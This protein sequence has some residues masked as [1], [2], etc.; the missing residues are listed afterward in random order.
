MC[1]T[2]AIQPQAP[3]VA[4][5]PRLDSQKAPIIEPVATC[6]CVV[7]PVR[8][9]SQFQSTARRQLCSRISPNVSNGR[10]L[11]CSNSRILECSNARI[12]TRGHTIS[13]MHLSRRRNRKPSNRNQCNAGAERRSTRF[14]RLPT[15]RDSTAPQWGPQSARL[16]HGQTQR[17]GDTEIQRCWESLKVASRRVTRTQTSPKHTHT[18]SREVR[19]LSKK[20]TCRAF[21]SVL[22]VPRGSLAL[23]RLRSLG[24]F[25]ANYLVHLEHGAGG[26]R[27]K[28]D[29]PEF[30]RVQI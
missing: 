20:H 12:T 13:P 27:R 6:G 9:G 5:I 3:T 28:L 4:N 14:H 7:G 26:A 21:A 1:P 25:G 30:G 16:R 10:T 29:A 11:E 15:P 23:G 19:F 8:E 22:V 24:R 2:R 18:N 17:H